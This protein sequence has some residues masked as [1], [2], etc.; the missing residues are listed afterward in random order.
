MKNLN[1]TENL[2]FVLYVFCISKDNLC[3]FI[4]DR[5]SLQYTATG[6]SITFMLQKIFSGNGSFEIID[7]IYL[8]K[9]TCNNGELTPPN[10][11]LSD[12]LV[13]NYYKLDHWSQRTRKYKPYLDEIRGTV[14]SRHKALRFRCTEGKYFL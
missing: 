2:I 9:S 13:S 4:E 3:I 12:I 6:K 7:P 14:C 11:G 5:M 1:A 8:F 10:T